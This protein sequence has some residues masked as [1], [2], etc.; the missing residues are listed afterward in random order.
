[1]IESKYGVDNRLVFRETFNSE[2]ECLKKHGD[3]INV[4]FVGGKGIFNGTT[5]FLSYPISLN[6]TYSVR[7]KF[8][9]WQPSTYFC[10]FRF[11]SGSGFCWIMNSSVVGYPTGTCYVN[12]ASTT[13]L[14]SDSTEVVL[15]GIT[16]ESTKLYLGAAYTLSGRISSNFDLFEI[17]EGTLTAS[18]VLNM[19]TNSTNHELA[20]LNKSLSSNKVVNGSFDTDTDWAKGPGWSISDGNAS[21]DGTQY[22]V[23]DQAIGVVVGRKYLLQYEIV[24]NISGTG[25]ALSS[26]SFMGTTTTLAHTVGIHFIEITAVTAGSLRFVI[27]TNWTG[28]IDN[29]LVSE[30]A[31]C[32]TL[33][34][35]TFKGVV[36]DK[37]VG[38]AISGD[39]ASGWDFT[40]GWSLSNISTSDSNSFTTTAYGGVY[41]S[42]V[43][44]GKKYIGYVKGTT[45]A[46]FFIRNAGAG[47]EFYTPT[48]TGDFES[49][50][51]FTPIT[52]SLYFAIPT[53]GTVTITSFILKE[54]TPSLE[55]NDVDIV[56]SGTTYTARFDVA[57]SNI[58][59][60]A[61]LI[62]A[63]DITV[64]SWFDFSFKSEIA[65]RIIDN[66]MF[67]VR[68]SPIFL[69]KISVT[70]STVVAY[71]NTV[72]DI[73]KKYF[74]AITRKSDGTANIYIGDLDNAP[75]LDSAIDAPTG[76]P[77]VGGVTY[78][79]NRSGLDK[80]LEGDMP[81]FKV[82]NGI[83]DL[84]EIT[85]VWSTTKRKV[86]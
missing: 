81:M 8:K 42:L 62:G 67:K 58:K 76:T 40:T 69:R 85:R 50:F 70:S 48:L 13:A 23:L 33:D 77:A 15:S 27:V 80:S 61:D 52:T 35:N 66:G 25:F 34:M 71:S 59:S 1:M 22:S 38:V 41:K 51:E 74:L 44:V 65:S 10:D 83:L 47:L 32:L 49:T 68:V 56:K 37:S 11:D 9:G 86:S 79:G 4:D 63:G 30:I 16:L 14:A 73:N 57:A 84:A 53:I 21:S 45:D 5:S 64:M 3:P 18:E 28:S 39:I 12:G 2:Q 6:G 75:I 29:V 36:E 20:G 43:T 19:A 78:L 55:I 46:S 54:I 26:A 24:E 72:L 7:I 17:Y 60:N 82:A 31:P